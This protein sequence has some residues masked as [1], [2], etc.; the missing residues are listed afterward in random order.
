MPVVNPHHINNSIYL[1]RKLKLFVG[2][3]D[4][5]EKKTY[6]ATLLVNI[7]ALGFTLSPE[8]ISVV[9]TLSN[10][11]LTAFYDQ[12]IADLK[13][14]VGANVVY[15]PMYPNFPQQVMR[16]SDAE[17]YFNSTI[18]YF[19]DWIGER[20]LP[21]YQKEK[22]TSLRD[23]IALKIIAPGTAEEFESIFTTLLRAKVAITPTDKSALAW[24]VKTYKEDIIHLL[25]A[26]IP[27]KENLSV[28]CAHIIE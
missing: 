26:D 8:L 14:M 20:I 23:K 11:Q 17:L 21:V 3:G 9:S 28:V 22:R 5:L 16:A 18:H 4:S 24:F 15:K 7:G 12:L 25:P 13:E 27:S 2:G 1:R 6:I 19:G 10:E